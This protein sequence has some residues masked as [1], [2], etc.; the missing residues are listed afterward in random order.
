MSDK[1][2]AGGGDSTDDKGRSEGDR[3]RASGEGD[4]LREG[5]GDSDRSREGRD[6]SDRSRDSARDGR[7][8]GDRTTVNI[9]NEQRTEVRSYFSSRRGSGPRVDRSAVSVSVGVAVPSTVVLEPA[10][11]IVIRTLPRGPRYVYFIWGSDV[12]IVDDST[13]EVVVIISDAA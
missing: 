11:D 13:R 2:K 8:G 1:D 6:G 7:G 12:V 4:R 9:T 10:P 3:S 5:G